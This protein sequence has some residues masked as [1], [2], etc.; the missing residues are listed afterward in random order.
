MI[1]AV[2]YDMDGTLYPL[3]P[4]R[5][6]MVRE[7]VWA[8]LHAPGKTWGDLR[9][10]RTYRQVLEHL[11]GAEAADPDAED[12]QLYAVAEKLAI[13]PEEVR[14]TADEWV[15]KRP[16]RF[17]RRIARPRLLQIIRL[18]HRADV[19]QG[20]YSD[21]RPQTKLQAMGIAGCIQAV[22]WSGQPGV[23]EFKPAPAGFLQVARLLGVKPA[24]VLY[25]GDRTGVDDVGAWAAGMQF[26]HV[27][28]FTLKR[29]RAM[30]GL[31]T[32][33]EPGAVELRG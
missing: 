9:M 11:R 14:A 12:P 3:W 8:F 22:V 13:P 16:L 2:A 26:L 27:R 5:Y 4:M 1:Q 28:Q 6:Y 7:L 15:T 19:R 31:T 33:P 30:L 21:Y 17:L 20:V 10:L 18:L 32:P 25:V 24:E 29:V 23:G